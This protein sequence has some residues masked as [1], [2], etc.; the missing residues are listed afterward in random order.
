MNALEGSSKDKN[1]RMENLKPSKQVGSGGQDDN[2]PFGF[3]SY[4]GSVVKKQFRRAH[5]FENSDRNTVPPS[6][7]RITSDYGR[8]DMASA[9]AERANL[10]KEFNPRQTIQSDYGHYHTTNTNIPQS[11]VV[12]ILKTVNFPTDKNSSQS[13]MSTI[14]KDDVSSILSDQI[15]DSKSIQSSLLSAQ[16]SDHKNVQYE[17]VL[18]TQQVP[19]LPFSFNPLGSWM[20]PNKRNHVI[21]KS[22]K[23]PSPILSPKSKRRSTTKDGVSPT[24]SPKSVQFGKAYYY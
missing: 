8:Y 3:I 15:S 11:E 23:N 18:P 5:F 17:Q 19:K 24:L 7:G 20:N 2:V 22:A 10:V 1:T 16:L 6:R 12:E 4:D 13:D 9:Q 14:G 21:S